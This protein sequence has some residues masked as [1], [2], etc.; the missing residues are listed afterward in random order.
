MDDGYQ[1][2]QL[3]TQ[4]ICL[5]NS[6]IETVRLP[7]FTLPFIVESVSI[8]HSLANAGYLQ[9]NLNQM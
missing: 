3:I 1:D 6:F 4:M 8:F 5:F 2:N 7:Q 9:S